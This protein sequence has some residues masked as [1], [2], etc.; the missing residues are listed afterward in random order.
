[1]WVE[2]Y[3]IDAELDYEEWFKS[4]VEEDYAKLHE[5]LIFK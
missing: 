5:T 2:D 3:D 4:T 1:M